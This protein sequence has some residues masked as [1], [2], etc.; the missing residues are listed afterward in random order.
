M[1]KKKIATWPHYQ[2]SKIYEIKLM[3]AEPRSKIQSVNHGHE[4]K[5]K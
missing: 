5:A 1:L 3:I 4:S 2:S